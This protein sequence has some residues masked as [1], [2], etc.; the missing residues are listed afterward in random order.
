MSI[1]MK[2]IKLVL[3]ILVFMFTA[4]SDKKNQ[5]T[6]DFF[7]SQ[8]RD[9]EL[10]GWWK[11]N[12]ET[13]SVFWHFKESG[14]ISELEYKDGNVYNDS[15]DRYYWYT[16]EREEKKILY[17]FY[18]RGWFEGKD[19]GNGYY[20]IEGDSLWKSAGIEGGVQPTE[21]YLFATKT[22]APKKR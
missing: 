7:L 5:E 17:E 13:D 22:T 8:P 21:L 11:W 15:E 16:E 10:I 2:K 6:I 4:C 14:T 19:Y 9:P 3:S 18:P 20:K 12:T 1:K